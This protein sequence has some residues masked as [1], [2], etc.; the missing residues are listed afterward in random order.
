MV[1]GTGR[2]TPMRANAVFNSSTRVPAQ[3]TIGMTGQPRWWRQHCGLDPYAL[4]A[5]HIDHIERQHQWQTHSRSW[6]VGIE[7]A[8]EI[9]ASRN[10][11]SSS[12]S[13]DRR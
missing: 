13:P 10:M 3:A 2:P 1:A 9:E 7:V 6:V 11:T 4:L 12:D 5:G 8:L